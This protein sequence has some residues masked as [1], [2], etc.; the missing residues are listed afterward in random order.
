MRGTGVAVLRLRFFRPLRGLA[1]ELWVA[2][3]GSVVG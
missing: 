1:R 3:G 2:L